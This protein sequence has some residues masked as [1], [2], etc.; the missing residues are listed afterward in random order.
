[1][2]KPYKSLGKHPAALML[3]SSGAVLQNRK[4]Y[5]YAPPSAVL[6]DVEVGNEVEVEVDEDDGDDG[7]F[8]EGAL[9]KIA[10]RYVK[11]KLVGISFAVDGVDRG[12]VPRAAL[13]SL[14]RAL[15]GGGLQLCCQPYKGGVA[16][17]VQHY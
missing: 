16:S 3:H 4:V 9:V 12:C 8:G 17:I 14:R 11:S 7:A 13:A 10:T 15:C 6:A 2:G 5:A 1:M